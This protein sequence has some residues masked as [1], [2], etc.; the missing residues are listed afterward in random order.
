MKRKMFWGVLGILGVFVFLTAAGA[1]DYPTKPIIMQV[2]YPA[3]AAPTW[4]PELYRP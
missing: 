1:Q 3:E 2:P 4:A